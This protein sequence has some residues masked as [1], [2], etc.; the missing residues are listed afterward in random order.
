MSG[1][2]CTYRYNIGVTFRCN[3]SLHHMCRMVASGIAPPPWKK[4]LVFLSDLLWD[5]LQWFTMSQPLQA[6]FCMLRN[7]LFLRPYRSNAYFCG[8]KKNVLC[9]VNNIYIYKLFSLPVYTTEFSREIMRKG[10]LD[11]FVRDCLCAGRWGDNYEL[12]EA[13]PGHVCP[14][15]P[16][17][18]QVAVLVLVPPVCWPIRARLQPRRWAP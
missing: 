13:Q 3:H 17:L 1:F 8:N 11:A 4:C 10:F 15:A 12:P 14:A 5:Y 7:R 9:T 6:R 16:A 2:W 18:W